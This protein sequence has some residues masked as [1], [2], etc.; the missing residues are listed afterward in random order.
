MRNVANQRPVLFGGVAQTID[1][2]FEVFELLREQVSGFDTEG[3]GLLF[4]YLQS[5]T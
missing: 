3:N 1:H 2:F 5:F 4:V